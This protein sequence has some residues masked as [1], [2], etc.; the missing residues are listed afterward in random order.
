MVIP[1]RPVSEPRVTIEGAE[2]PPR[3]TL[4]IILI[5]VGLVFLLN[6]FIPS[7]LE[8]SL[9]HC[10]NNPWSFYIYNERRN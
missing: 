9:A 5:L 1:P 10:F 6:N 3:Q 7:I 4:G 8:A 2:R